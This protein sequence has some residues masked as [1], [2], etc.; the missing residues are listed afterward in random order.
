MSA[1]PL[2]SDEPI[3]NTVVV[4]GGDVESFL[5]ARLRFGQAVLHAAIGVGMAELAVV[6]ENSAAATAGFRLWD[7]TIASLRDQLR[8]VGWVAQRPGQLEVVRRIDNLVQ[9]TATLGDDCTGDPASTPTFK[10]EKGQATERAVN[11]NQRSL[12]DISPADPAWG[13]IETWWL[14]YKIAVRDSETFVRSELSLPS[15]IEGSR[16]TQWAYRVILDERPHGTSV[17]AVVPESA[18][19]P[20]VSITRRRPA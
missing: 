7:G 6:T 14:L 15:R 3:R 4:T 8:P 17:P 12:G 13:A 1:T 5:S 9:V 20:S 16:V 19:T 2:F 11:G 18:P 10:H